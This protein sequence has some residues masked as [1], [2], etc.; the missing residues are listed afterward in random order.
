[1]LAAAASRVSQ[2]VAGL[3]YL[4]LLQGIMRHFLRSTLWHKHSPA[5]IPSLS[6]CVLLPAV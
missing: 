1:M 5:L 2:P 3:G 6:A 4:G